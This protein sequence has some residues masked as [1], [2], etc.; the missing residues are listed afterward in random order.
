MNST[1]RAAVD[2]LAGVVAAARRFLS[3]LHPERAATKRPTEPRSPPA[4]SRLAT[5]AALYSVRQRKHPKRAV[6]VEETVFQNV[7]ADQTLNALWMQ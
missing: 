7:P 2:A 3:R 4:A 1:R 6:V 5:V